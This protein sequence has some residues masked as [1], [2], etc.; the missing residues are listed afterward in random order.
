MDSLFVEVNHVDIGRNWQNPADQRAYNAN[1]RVIASLFSVAGFQVHTHPNTRL[2]VS[3]VEMLER[4]LPCI[5][6]YTNFTCEL[7]LM[8]MADPKIYEVVMVHCHCKIAVG[9]FRGDHEEVVSKI[10]ELPN[11][12]LE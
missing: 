1:F 8:D 4:F 9:Q 6:S 12:G 10:L 5:L 7:V 2:E 11:A 3:K